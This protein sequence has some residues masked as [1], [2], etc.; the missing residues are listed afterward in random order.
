M[1]TLQTNIS[2]IVDSTIK[3]LFHM[4]SVNKKK[5]QNLPSVKFDPREELRTSLSA[6]LIPRKVLKKPTIREIISSQKIPNKTSAKFIP[7]KN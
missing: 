1:K 7:R 5:E 4:T 6:K 3:S 2:T